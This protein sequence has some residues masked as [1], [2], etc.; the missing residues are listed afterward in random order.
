MPRNGT[1]AARGPRALDL[2]NFFVADVQT[3]FGPFIAVYLT[4]HKWTQVQIG[5]TLTLGTVVAL[6]SQV[7][8]GALVDAVR[9]KRAA[10]SGALI[11]VV[12]AALLLA[13][14]P[15]TLPVMIAQSLHAFSSCVLTPAIAAIS[16]HL[17]GHTALGERLGRNARYASIGNGLA[18]AVMGATG[19]WLSSRAVFVLTAALCVPALGSLMAIGRGP[20]SRRQTTT[21]LFDWP[22]LR[23]LFSDHRLLVFG[24][25][26]MLFHL[27]N[28]AMLPL[29]GAAVTMRA[30]GF[31]NVIIAA[32]I[33]LPQ[34]VV[35]VCSPAVGR[36]A[37][38]LGRRPVLLL[39]WSAL[40]LRGL[41]LAVLPGA[42]LPIAA[43]TMSGVSAAVFGVMLPLLAADITRGT[44]HFNLCMGALGLAVSLGAALSTT[45]G[46]WVADTVGLQPAFAVLGMIGAF[47]TLVLWLT[48]PETRPDGERFVPQ[49]VT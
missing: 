6:M 17:V 5:F 10:A 48:M 41:L 22:G 43:Q 29:V 16:L 15:T 3:G 37:A 31:A 35:A 4:T 14:Q 40:P 25:C 27:S 1:V 23:R 32:C 26:V 44:S 49:R 13:I 38:L 20:Y 11:G 34:I 21:R 9:N 39:G 33:V 42:W 2:L 12:I 45:L 24:V 30:E 46:G 19:A 47:A 8:A 36:N 28:A 18:A 7:P